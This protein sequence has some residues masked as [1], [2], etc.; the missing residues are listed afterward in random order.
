MCRT[1]RHDGRTW[2]I[3]L[4]IDVIWKVYFVTSGPRTWLS[5]SGGIRPIRPS[6]AASRPRNARPEAPEHP[7]GGGAGWGGV[8]RGGGAAMLLAAALWG[9]GVGALGK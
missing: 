1:K 3:R 6:S 5:M 9:P 8:G 7:G 4:I 2:D